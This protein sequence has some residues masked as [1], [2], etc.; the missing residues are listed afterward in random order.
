MAVTEFQRSLTEGSCIF[1]VFLP[2]IDFILTF[3][4]YGGEDVTSQSL[5]ASLGYIADIPVNFSVTDVHMWY[6]YLLIGLYL[7]MPVFSAW[8]EKASE[9]AKLCFL[10]AWG[11]TLFIPYIREFVSPYIWGECSWNEFGMLYYFAGFNG[12][13][14]LG[15]VLRRHVLPM[16]TVRTA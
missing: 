3:F 9:K 15:H 14:L 7:F 6:I 1:L 8:I 10:A 5:S 4:P 2:C 16:R 13:L 12:Y 11:V